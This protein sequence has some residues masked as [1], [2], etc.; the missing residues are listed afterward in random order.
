MLFVYIFSYVALEL[1]CHA[2]ETY[3]NRLNSQ[4]EQEKLKVHCRRALLELLFH[5]KRPDLRHKGLKTVKNSHLLTFQDYVTKATSDFLDFVPMIDFQDPEIDEK[6]GYWWKVVAFYT[7]R[8]LFAPLIETLVL[9]DRC[10]YLQEKGL[11][12]SL[13]ALFDPEL[14][15]RNFVIYSVKS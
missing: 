7:L 15:P 8:L 2:I 9:I 4:E 13:A 3:K 12:C 10:L 14:S 6:L 5:R 1:A 11:E